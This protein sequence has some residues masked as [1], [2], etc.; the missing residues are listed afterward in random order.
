MKLFVSDKCLGLVEALGEFYP[1]ARW[2]RCVV[3]FYRNVFTVVPRGKVRQVAAMLKAIHAQE[4][5]EAAREK[6]RAVAKKLEAMKLRKA[7]KVVREGM[8]ETFS[9]YHFPSE[10]WR[11]IRTNNPL[12]RVL[13]E[14]RRRTRVVGCFPDGRSALMLVCARLRHVSGTK[15]GL[16]RYMSMERLREVKE[17][18]A[19]AV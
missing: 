12:E 10:H 16:R 17:A 2:Q 8:E 1:E 14:V 15:W 11:Q 19:V 13:R 5:L 7:A 3:H 4:D 18:A 6:A 9:Y